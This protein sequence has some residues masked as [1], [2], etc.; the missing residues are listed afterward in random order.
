M[1]SFH[2]RFFA[3]PSWISF[4]FR[5]VS[6]L[7]CSFLP[8]RFYC[9]FIQHFPSISP[10]FYLLNGFYF[11]TTW[12]DRY[13]CDLPNA[14]SNLNQCDFALIIFCLVQH[15]TCVAQNN[16]LSKWDGTL[17]FLFGRILDIF[18]SRVLCSNYLSG[19]LYLNCQSARD[20]TFS[21]WNMLSGTVSRI[22]PR[23]W[24]ICSIVHRY[25]LYQL[26]L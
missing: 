18:C 22:W 21:R 8:I 5:S 17:S 13:K 9:P 12:S 19:I 14:E 23:Q 6:R 16:Y 26:L 10:Y 7:F 1:H 11:T 3:S 25:H 4:F 20:N 24:R 15:E 2:L